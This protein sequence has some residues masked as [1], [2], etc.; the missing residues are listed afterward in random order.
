MVL[1][2]YSRVQAHGSR[3]QGII[4]SQLRD[5]DIGGL[6]VVDQGSRTDEMEPRNPR[7]TDV[8]NKLKAFADKTLE[9]WGH[10]SR[11]GFSK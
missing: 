11:S 7:G 3:N 8:K 2:S 1:S 6:F 4:A 9:I 10:R 5:K